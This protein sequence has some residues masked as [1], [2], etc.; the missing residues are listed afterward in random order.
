MT[1]SAFTQ[2]PLAFIEE[3]EEEAERLTRLHDEDPIALQDAVNTSRALVDAVKAGD[4]EE[5]QNVV[6]N[7]E[8]GELLQVFTL[9]AFVLALKSASLSTVKT[10]VNWGVPLGHENL[11]QAIHLVCE[12]TTRNNFSD[13]WRIVQLLVDGNSEGRIDINTPRVADGWTPLCIA[14]A[15]AC[16]PL[17]FKLLEFKADPNVVTRS[18]ATPLALAK[19][20]RPDDTEEQREARGIIANMLQEYGAQ[21]S[22]RDSLKAARFPKKRPEP[23]AEVITEAEDGSKMVQQVLSNTHTRFSA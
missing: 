19:L 21:E 1:A 18:N 9:Q 6:E 3:P 2:H 13:A 8:E 11:S 5:M 22:Y 15:D 4:L 20:K 23:K 14:C 10:L 7:A 17:A 16:L 12:V